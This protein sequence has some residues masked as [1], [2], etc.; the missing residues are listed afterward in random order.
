MDVPEVEVAA[1]GGELA[2]LRVGA[3]HSARGTGSHSFAVLRILLS[4]NCQKR[5]Y[6][7]INH[8]S[9]AGNANAVSLVLLFD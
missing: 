1:V 3:C 7:I 2:L 6:V 5:D 4:E 8:P 9:D